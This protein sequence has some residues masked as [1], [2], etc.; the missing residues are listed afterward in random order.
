M[1]KI[2]LATAFAG[3]L[4]EQTGEVAPVYRQSIEAILKA[5]REQPDLEVFCAPEDDGWKMPSDPPAIS[6]TAD[7]EKLD[8]SDMLI[9]LIQDKPSV[10]VQFEMGYAVA[11][12]KQVTLAMAAG[13]ELGSYNQGLV[14][15]GMMT[16]I[17]YDT[18]ADL[19]THLPLAV[20]EP[21]GPKT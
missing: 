17:T 11:K 18:P 15:A 6:L 2:F 21:E 13:A 5:L 16:L 3:H 1:K 12:G 14:S 10:G 9:A 19:K 20:N 8:E 4:N 7:L